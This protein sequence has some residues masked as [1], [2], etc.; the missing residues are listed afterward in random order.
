MKTYI[1]LTVCLLFSFKTIHAQTNDIKAQ[2]AYIQAYEAFE[3]GSFTDA[4]KYLQEA[5]TLLG[6]TNSKIQYLLVKSLLET[7]D[8]PGV[9]EEV[10]VYFNVTPETARDERY[11][12]MVKSVAIADKAIADKEKQIAQQK[13]AAEAGAKKRIEYKKSEISRLESQIK[14]NKGK[15]A[16]KRLKGILAIGGAVGLGILYGKSGETEKLDDGTTVLV[17]L[18]GLAGFVSGCMSFVNA[19]ELKR[20]NRFLQHHLEFLS[21]E[22]KVTLTPMYNP[23]VGSVGLCARI[24]F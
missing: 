12:E 8:Y 6:K 22:N 7:K 13:V 18:T 20:E 19:G 15:I 23:A 10:K 2:S 5:K 14:Q 3:R 17:A 1:I 11:E 4:T 9:K 21:I 16:G 24:K